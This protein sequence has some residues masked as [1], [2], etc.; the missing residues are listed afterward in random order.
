M[1]SSILIKLIRQFSA[2][3]L[4][5]LEQF[6]F[7]PFFMQQPDVKSLLKYIIQHSNKQPAMLKKETAFACI[8]PGSAYQDVQMRHL[9]SKLLKTVKDF[10]RQKEL[11][12]DHQAQKLFYLRALKRRN[13]QFL[14]EKEMQEKQPDQAIHLSESAYSGHINY[15]LLSEKMDWLTSSEPKE[16]MHWEPINEVLS[17]NFIAETLRLA[18][19]AK[20][21]ESAGFQANKPVLLDEVLRLAAEENYVNKARIA[22]YY[23]GYLSLV[24]PE[25][26]AHFFELKNAIEKFGTR[27][28]IAELRNIYMM[29]INYSIRRLNSGDKKYVR[30]AFDLYRFG[31]KN[32]ILLENEYL[33]ERTYRNILLLG[34]DLNEKEWCQRYLHDYK[35]ALPPA[36]RENAWLYALAFYHYSQKEYDEAQ[37]FL[38]KVDFSNIAINLDARRMLVRIYYEKK[39][40]TSLEFLLDSFKAWLHRHKELAYYRESYVNYI[41]FVKKILMLKN[42]DKETLLKIKKEIEETSLLAERN[43]L[44]SLVE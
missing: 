29:A 4:K 36:E 34:M 37:V 28:N 12:M 8:Y 6:S 2:K 43:W 14:F 3:E 7:Y 13:L 38:H 19:A 18:C 26:E 41:R 33:P 5:E 23:R 35:S 16:N 11:D 15:L 22:V 30:E 24:S 20:S 42:H 9:M 31:L 21:F 25:N 17:D 40:F 44:I 10:I 39:D 1:N 27:F 32:K